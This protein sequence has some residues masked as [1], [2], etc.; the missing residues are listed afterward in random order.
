VKV[1]RTLRR[2]VDEIDIVQLPQGFQ[3]AVPRWMLDPVACSRLPQEAK[4]RV[5]LS[6]LLRMAELVEKQRLP[7]GS[8]AALLDTST[9]T[10]GHHVSR[11]KSALSSSPVASSQEDALGPLPGTDPS[12]VSSTADSTAAP[13]RA[14]WQQGKEQR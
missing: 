4:P 13:S 6:A 2:F 3:I 11:Q 9:S 7:V 8:D 1:V 5:A 14:Q 12:S 10:K